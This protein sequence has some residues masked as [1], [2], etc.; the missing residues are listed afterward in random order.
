MIYQPTYRQLYYTADLRYDANSETVSKLYGEA[1][2]GIETTQSYDSLFVGETYYHA[3]NLATVMQGIQ[4][5]EYGYYV[6]TSEIE[7][8]S[9]TYEF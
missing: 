7:K 2:I 1:A 3:T 5:N 6:N 8:V 4:Q 9:A